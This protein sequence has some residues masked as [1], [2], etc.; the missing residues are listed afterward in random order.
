MDII[1]F[2]DIFPELRDSRDILRSG[3]RSLGYH[4]EGSYK[5]GHSI[6]ESILGS[7]S[8]GKL[9]LGSFQNNLGPCVGSPYNQD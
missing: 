9:L 3:F 1:Y 7:P 8:L 6:L 2:K 5:K 4:F